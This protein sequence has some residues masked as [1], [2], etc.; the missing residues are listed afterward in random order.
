MRHYLHGV[1]AE[2][3]RECSVGTILFSPE[4]G[5]AQMTVAPWDGVEGSGAHVHIESW[6]SGTRAVQDGARA[7][8]VMWTTLLFGAAGEC[9][10]RFAFDFHPGAKKRVSTFALALADVCICSDA[11]LATVFRLGELSEAYRER[12]VL[13]CG[14]C[15]EREHHQRP[16]SHSQVTETAFADVKQNQCLHCYDPAPVRIRR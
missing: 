12:V 16:V 14:A 5:E 15:R 8:R 3:L 11:V 9:A 6:P 7:T 2:K 10:V 1:V 13:E 4:V